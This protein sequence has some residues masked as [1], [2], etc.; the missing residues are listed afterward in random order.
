MAIDVYVAFAMDRNPGR[1]HAAAVGVVDGVP[2]ARTRFAGQ[3]V[4]NY[5]AAWVA[6]DLAL[7]RARGRQVTIWSTLASLEGP[8]PLPVYRGWEKEAYYDIKE[9]CTNTLL[10]GAGTIRFIHKIKAPEWMRIAER[11][12]HAALDKGDES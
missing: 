4:T 5:H 3:R 12:A 11:S 6:I 9:R 8:R 1:A 2:H 10:S 7:E